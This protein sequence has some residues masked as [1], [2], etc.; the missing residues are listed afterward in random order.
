MAFRRLSSS[1]LVASGY[2]PTSRRYGDENG[3]S[4]SYRQYR[5]LYELSDAYKPLDLP[6]LAKQRHKQAAFNDLVKAKADQIRAERLAQIDTRNMGLIEAARAERDALASV[7]KSEIL[8]SPEF[9]ADRARLVELG[10][11]PVKRM[12]RSEK[13]E[14]KDVLTRLGRR[15]GIPR[16]VEVGD[17]GKFLG[18]HMRRA[19]NG[20][21]V[22]IAASKTGR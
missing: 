8:K 20:R 3:R 5:G 12:T 6:S 14:L 7:K 15:D 2:A 22:S 10:K 21:Y 16:G 17:S 11:K 9:K 18:G 4:I 1:E 19:G 13:T